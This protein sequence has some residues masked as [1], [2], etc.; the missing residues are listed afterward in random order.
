MIIETDDILHFGVKGMKWGVRNDDSGSSKPAKE[1]VKW[2][3]KQISMNNM[4]DVMNTAASRSGPLVEKIN[5]K[6]AYK[7]ADFSQPSALRA[8]YYEEHR[9]GY[10]KALNDVAKERG[11]NS[12]GGRYR[13][14]IV[15]ENVGSYPSFY[16]YDNTI[17]HSTFDGKLQL[18][19]KYSPRGHIVGYEKTD[20]VLEQS[21]TTTEDFLA[22]FGIKGMKWGVRRSPEQLGRKPGISKAEQG[23][24]DARSKAS[25]NRRKLSDADIRARIER[26]QLEKRLKDL[27]EEDLSPGKAYAKQVITQAGK[28]AL[29]SALTG[30]ALYAVKYAL[31]REFN[32]REAA[33]YLAPRPKNK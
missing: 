25:E 18:I 21:G 24:R 2:A 7:D 23:R 20:E 27:T 17:A 30:A 13:L 12:P 1:D 28:K 9:A 8:K 22:H 15:V 11:N 19:P 26:M 16:I 33:G 31:T 14:E 3:R 29:S 5:S 4:I 6:P 10:Q 32:A